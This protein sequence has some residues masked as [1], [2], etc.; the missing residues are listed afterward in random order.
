MSLHFVLVLIPVTK[1]NIQKQSVGHQIDNPKLATFVYLDVFTVPMF[2]NNKSCLS[3]SH[4]VD[5]RN[6]IAFIEHILVFRDEVR[7]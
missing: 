7:L 4:K 2:R 5:T 3:L 6:I 1:I